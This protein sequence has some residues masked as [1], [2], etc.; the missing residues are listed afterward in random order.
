M[1][2]HQA[3]TLINKNLAVFS[4]TDFVGFGKLIENSSADVSE[5][6]TIVTGSNGTFALKLTNKQALIDLKNYIEN[7][8]TN[9]EA[10]KSFNISID[11]KMSVKDQIKGLLQFINETTPDG[12]I[13][14]YQINNNNEWELKQL[15]DNNKVKSI[16][17]S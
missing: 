9:A 5:Y 1:H 11:N 13:E 15:D 16:K 2:C 7:P 4:I 6:I 10:E 17:C 3:F 14:L 8:S 12:G